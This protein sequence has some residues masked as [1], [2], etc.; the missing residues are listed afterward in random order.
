MN[1]N[2]SEL[3]MIKEEHDFELMFQRSYAHMIE[4]M[5]KDLIAIKIEANDLIESQR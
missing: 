4:R 5:K 2:D 3:N 1:S